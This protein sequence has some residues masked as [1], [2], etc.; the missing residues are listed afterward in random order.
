MNASGQVHPYPSPHI[1]ISK[2]QKGRQAGEG[3]WGIKAFSSQGGHSLLFLREGGG[4]GRKSYKVCPASF[5]LEKK[6]TFR[7]APK[8]FRNR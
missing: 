2:Q 6:S 1:C 8:Q 4:R 3:P 5:I 7:E